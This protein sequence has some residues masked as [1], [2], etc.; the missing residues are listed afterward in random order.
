MKNT[1][2]KY[3]YRIAPSGSR[4]YAEIFH[5]SGS[6]EIHDLSKDFDHPSKGRGFFS[7]NEWLYASPTKQQYEDAQSW[8]DEQMALIYKYC[9]PS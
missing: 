8:A 9:Q 5:M 6:L 2:I 4:V 1:K 7:G 3:E